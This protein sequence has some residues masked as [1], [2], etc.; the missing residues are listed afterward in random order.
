MRVNMHALRKVHG[1]RAGNAAGSC[2]HNAVLV[3]KTRATVHDW[4]HRRHWRHSTHD[5]GDGEVSDC[6]VWRWRRTATARIAVP[7]DSGSNTYPWGW[8][9]EWGECADRGS[10]T[11]VRGERDPAGDRA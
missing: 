9:W 6:E 1:R 2:R 11:G 5:T 4:R 8:L 7:Y 3:D 10:L